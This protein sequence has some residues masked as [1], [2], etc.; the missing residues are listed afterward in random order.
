MSDAPGPGHNRAPTPVLSELVSP[1]VIADI[2]AAELDREPMSPDGSAIPSIRERD[3][4]LMAMCQRFLAKYP[5]IET[6]EAEAIATEVLSTCGKFASGSGRVENARQ[7]LK[8]PVLDAGRAIDAAFAKFGVQLEIRPLTGPVKDRRAAPFTLAEQINKLVSDYKDAVDRKQREEAA[9]LAKQKAEEAALAEQMAK[10]GS[11]TVT[12]DDAVAAAVE[13]EAAQATVDAP[14][15]ALTRSKGGDFGSTSRKRVRTFTIVNP[16]LIPRHLCI[17][18]DSLIRDAI[19][20]A[21]EPMP[22]IPGVLITDQT[23]LVRR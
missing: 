5:K 15:A 14:M 4:A 19:G 11:G 16:A 6:P 9:A 21:D 7:A 3:T 17:P 13:A 2:I 8:Q 12:M 23:D 10:R 1:A 22:D 18:S 20:K